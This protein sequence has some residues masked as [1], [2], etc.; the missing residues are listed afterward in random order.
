MVKRTT[1]LTKADNH[2]FSCLH[3][4]DKRPNVCRA[5]VLRLGF[6]SLFVVFSLFFS[7][8]SAFSAVNFLR[9]SRIFLF[10]PDEG[11]RMTH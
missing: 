7:A 10:F 6:C 2:H 1:K 9:G 4:V 3:V 11:S 5:V 8:L